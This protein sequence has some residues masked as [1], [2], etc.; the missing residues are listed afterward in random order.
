MTAQLSGAFSFNYMHFTKVRYLGSI[1]GEQFLLQYGA[2][3]LN[4]QQHDMTSGQIVA[5]C[6]VPSVNI[7]GYIGYNE[8]LSRSETFLILRES[9][10]GN[11]L[12]T[13]PSESEP[14]PSVMLAVL[15]PRD[16]GNKQE[17]GQLRV[18]R[19]FSLQHQK[20]TLHKYDL[21][22]GA[23]AITQFGVEYIA[24]SLLEKVEVYNIMAQQ[25]V[26]DISFSG[27]FQEAILVHP[28]MNYRY[29]CSDKFV[30]ETMIGYKYGTF[31][32][33]GVVCERTDPSQ[34]PDWEE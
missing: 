17:L 1:P 27:V 14:E 6:I 15:S 32:K 7:P 23:N 9:E 25:K 33:L 18:F 26:R 29:F 24:V 4:I 19:I 31:S 21:S 22:S 16:V 34:Y 11:I 30:S 3:S 5:R 10:S 12:K 2:Q 20:N 8:N 13:Q 28:T